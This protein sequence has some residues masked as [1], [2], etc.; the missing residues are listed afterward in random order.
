IGNECVFR[1]H[2]CTAFNRG[3]YRHADV[4]QIFQ[5][6]NPF[7]VSLAPDCGIGNI[8]K[9]REIYTWDE[10]PACARQDHDL[11]FTVLRDTIKALDKVRVVQRSKSQRTTIAV[12]LADQHTLG[13]TA[14][15]YAAVSG[16]I[17]RLLLLHDVLQS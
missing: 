14:S 5:D 11:V 3:N 6:L 13:I 12:E 4:C 9:G 2:V 1:M 8:A 15:F 17:S 16:E 7:V 10:F